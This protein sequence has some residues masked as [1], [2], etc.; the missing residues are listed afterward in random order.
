MPKNSKNEKKKALFDRNIM[1]QHFCPGYS[2]YF[3]MQ[4]KY[5][6]ICM[7]YKNYQQF[8]VTVA[9][10]FRFRNLNMAQNLLKFKANFV[11]NGVNHRYVF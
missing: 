6:I 3:N 5:V 11:K 2:K 8:W 4:L 9:K 1:F 10:D 7:I